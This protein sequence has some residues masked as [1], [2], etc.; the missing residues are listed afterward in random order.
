MPRSLPTRGALALILTLAAGA[1]GASDIVTGVNGDDPVLARGNGNK[2]EIGRYNSLHAVFQDTSLI[3]YTSSADG[4]TW[5]EPQQISSGQVSSLPA[6][7]ASGSRVAAVWVEYQD[8]DYNQ[9]FPEVHY[10]Y[11]T[12]G[13]TT[14]TTSHLV[15][16][17]SEPAIAVR[18]TT[19]Y[20]TWSTGGSVQMTSFPVS[21]PPATLSLG[22]VV[23]YSSCPN[24]R[25]VRPSIALV[26]KS[27]TTVPKVAYLVEKDEQTTV[28]ACQSSQVRIGPKVESL[29]AGV[30]T[31]VYDGTRV[32][33]LAGSTVEA[34]SL[35]LNAHYTT[36]NLYLA[37]SD[38]LSGSARTRLVTGLDGTWATPAVVEDARLHVHVRPN[39]ASWGGPGS[40][41]LAYSHEDD[42]DGSGYSRTGS[43]VVGGALS[44]GAPFDFSNQTVRLPQVQFWRTLLGGG[45][46]GSATLNHYFEEE[47]PLPQTPPNLVTDYLAVPFSWVNNPTVLQA[48][49]CHQRAISI[50]G[51]VVGGVSGTVIDT[52][53]VGNLTKVT[54]RGA[55]ITTPEGKTIDISWSTGKVERSDETSLALTAPRS[56][57]RITSRDAAFTIQDDGHLKEYDRVQ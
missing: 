4:T 47:T 28:G 26:R 41:R 56:A 40:F 1:A 14:W 37:W 19:A 17:G 53:E 29:E 36:R 55:T 23:E 57:V 16:T 6:V 50:A 5:T 43:W 48:Y 9:M 39:N 45:L 31:Q 8:D 11:R 13:A 24:T 15:L 34:I 12:Y 18:G 54:D 49:P 27:C 2:I 25:F 30:W 20:V 46:L 22:D 35:S 33:T 32:S 51:M 3:F 38:D 52:A 10:G 44:W 7:A 42:W 21:S